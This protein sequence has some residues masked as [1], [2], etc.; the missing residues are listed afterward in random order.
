MTELKSLLLRTEPPLTL[1]VAESLTCGRVQAA[2]GA[3]S[4]ASQFFLGGLTAYSGAQKV[5]HLG[6]SRAEGE[7]VNYVSAAVA[8]QMA[9]GACRLFGADLAVA[10]TGYAEPSPEHGVSEPFAWWALA[11]WNGRA[12]DGKGG[13]GERMQSA[14]TSGAEFFVQS[15]RVACPGA[16]SR[17]AVQET[18]TA[19]AL[20]ALCDYLRSL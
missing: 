19:A 3:I 15:G 16:L 9:R 4:G 5:A 2:I 6:V 14:N 10:T 20:G 12:G 1:A 7:L 17:L 11:R 8:E 18:V 13:R